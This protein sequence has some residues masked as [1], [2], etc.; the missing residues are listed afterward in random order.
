MKF[1]RKLLTFLCIA[2][3]LCACFGAFLWLEYSVIRVPFLELDYQGDKLLIQSGQ[4]LY[5]LSLHTAERVAEQ[6]Q[7]RWI[8]LPRSL[9]LSLQGLTWLY[10]RE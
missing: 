3:I 5:R 2:G 8:L 1:L 10:L 6:L 9:R 4:E 7:R